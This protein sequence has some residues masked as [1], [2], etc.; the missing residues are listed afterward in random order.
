MS[1][2]EIPAHAVPVGLAP[3]AFLALAAGFLLFY[4]G[5]L[6][7]VRQQGGARA[8]LESVVALPPSPEASPAA[9]PAKPA[10]TPFEP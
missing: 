3:R 8:E 9:A 2:P 1:R 4:A 5:V 6:V 7:A 10:P